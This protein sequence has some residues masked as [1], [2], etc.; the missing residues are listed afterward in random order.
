V[1]AG[2]REKMWWHRK[3]QDVES[4]MVPRLPTELALDDRSE[5]LALE[6]H[7]CSLSCSGCNVAGADWPIVIGVVAP[8]GNSSA[9]SVAP[10][11]SPEKATPADEE[12]FA[13]TAEFLWV[14][15]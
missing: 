15:I 3:R 2:E 5:A 10:S 6:L 8:G 12:P 9:E 7:A 4:V 14:L 1:I 13:I 11:S